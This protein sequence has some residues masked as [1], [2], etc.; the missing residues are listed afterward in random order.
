MNFFIDFEATQFSE[1]IISIGCIAD[2]GNTFYTLVKPAQKKDKVNDFITKL[3]GITN[4][5]LATAPSAD[6]AFNAFF[7]F[8]CENSKSEKAIFYCYGEADASFIKH[9]VSHM[10]DLKAV[11]FATA[12]QYTM[13]NFAASVKEY[14]HTNYEIALRKVYALITG[15]LEDQNHNALEDAIM[16]RAVV[17][18]MA[19]KCKSEDVEKLAAMPKAAKPLKAHLLQKAPKMFVEWPSDKWEADTQADKDNWK[20]ACVVGPHTKYF[21]DEYVCMMWLIRYCVEGK[22]VKNLKHQEEIIERL[23]AALKG[24]AKSRHP[25]GFTWLKNKDKEI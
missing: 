21:N 16:L 8:V 1:R 17:N 10:N 3:T 13:I 24:T 12:L 14:F 19:D 18:Q 23:R 2:N 4:E 7:D 22:S 9:T 5:M 20:F 6:D 25:F 11:C 15:T